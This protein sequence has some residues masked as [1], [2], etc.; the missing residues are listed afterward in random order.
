MLF[1]SILSKMESMEMK[2]VLNFQSQYIKNLKYT[3]LVVG[4]KADL[5]KSILEK[6]G[7]VV[8]LTLEDIF[9]Y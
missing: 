1:R 4:K 9:G 6:Y 7:E 2:D 5:N 3:S 8:Y